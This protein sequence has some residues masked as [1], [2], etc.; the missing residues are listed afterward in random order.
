MLGEYRD[1]PLPPWEEP[2][3]GCARAPGAMREGEERRSVPEG[4]KLHV[5][6]KRG[7]RRGG[8]REVITFVVPTYP[9]APHIVQPTPGG[10]C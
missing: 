10:V 8:M 3:L 2:I 9:M 1:A 6:L 7:T 5:T 4:F